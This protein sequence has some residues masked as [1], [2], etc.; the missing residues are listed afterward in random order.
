[1]QLQ[2]LPRLCSIGL[3]CVTLKRELRDSSTWTWYMERHSSCTAM[4]CTYLRMSWLLLCCEEGSMHEGTERSALCGRD[5][6]EHGTEHAHPSHRPLRHVMLLSTPS[7]KR[8]SSAG[9]HSSLYLMSNVSCR[10]S[11]VTD[12]RGDAARPTDEGDVVCLCASRD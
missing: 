5:R 8:K 1:M 11:R 9:T 4:D 7:P 12:T 6:R 3:V 2:T 10:A